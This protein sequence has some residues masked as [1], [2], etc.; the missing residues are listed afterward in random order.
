MRTPLCQLTKQP[1]FLIDIGLLILLALITAIFPAWYV[2]NEHQFYV[3]DDALY[4]NLVSDIFLTFQDSKPQAISQVLESLSW[5]YNLLFTLPLVPF[6]IAFGDSRLVYILTLA[7]VY[8]LPFNLVMGA[9]AT[10]II[11]VYPRAIF[12]S[13]AFLTFLLPTVWNPT[14]YGRPDIGGILLIT[15]A[16]LVYLQ[17]VRLKKQWQIPIIGILLALAMLFRRHFSYS[18]IAFLSAVTM[19]TLILFSIQVRQYPY[20]ALRCFAAQIFRIFLIAA[21][22]IATL[23]TLSWRLIYRISGTDYNALYASYQESF[24][25]VFEYYASSYGWA[26]WMLVLLGFSAGIL[27]R[28]VSLPATIFISLFG[29]FSLAEWLIVLRYP[30]PHYTLHFAPLIIL[31]LVTFF[32][33]SLI[34]FKGKV[35]SLILAAYCLYLVSN[36]I[37]VLTPFITFNNTSIRPIFSTGSPP[38]VSTDYEEFTRLINTL[39]KLAPAKEPIYIAAAS[40]AFNHDLVENAE[41]TLYGRECV[42]LNTISAPVIDSR[43]FYPLKPLL[44]AQYVV[45]ASPFQHV[46]RAK[47]QDVVK[48]VVDAFTQNW[49]IS[50]DFKRLPGEFTLQK[51]SALT[52]HIY[53]EEST[54]PKNSTV[55]LHIYQRI[56]PTSLETAIRTFHIMEEQIDE[57][58]GS[59]SDWIILSNLF[60]AAITQNPNNTYN[61]VTY[62]SPRHKKPTASYLYI[63]KLAKKIKITGTVVLQNPQCVNLSLRWSILSNE[64]NVLNVT[65]IDY[66]PERPHNFG[67]SLQNPHTGY[68]LLDVL[69]RDQNHLIDYCSTQINNLLISP[70]N[71]LKSG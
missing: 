13:T 50:Q 47:E 17:D 57:R 23:I 63:G 3:W 32:W 6:F 45:V 25:K 61:L 20:K 4:H 34:N 65:E 22:S 21:T 31:G 14:L 69:S 56:R 48:V 37:S 1:K 41:L 60:P 10:K 42:I 8:F 30:G 39:R 51:N 58:P 46:L 38:V 28:V 44:Q 29:L 71:S 54:L 9:V 26:T 59:Q 27:T 12:W 66:S 18:S 43:D 70:L 5:D 35:R 55:T 7:L 16:A 67:I 68:L 52:L 15:L 62:P 49:E 33:T 24:S 53:P 36:F 40:A 11:P 19:Y 64:G 2:S